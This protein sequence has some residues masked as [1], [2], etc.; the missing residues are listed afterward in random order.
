MPIVKMPDGSRVKFPDDMTPEQI[1][2]VIESQPP[3]AP[4][5]P[6]PEAAPAAP[7]AVPMSDFGP[8]IPREAPPAPAVEEPLPAPLG[9]FGFDPLSAFPTQHRMRDSQSQAGLQGTARG[10]LDTIG[11]PA[12][13]L[14]TA[15]TLPVQGAN[16]LLDTNLP[17]PGSPTERAADSLGAL[18]SKYTG[19]DVR[20]EEDMP[21][22]DRLAYNA[23]RYGTGGGLVGGLLSKIGQARNA[24][25]GER[26][27]RAP[28]PFDPIMAPYETAPGRAVAQDVAAG[29][30]GGTALGA[31]HNAGVDNPL[32]DT[33]ALFLGAPA[34]ITAMNIVESPAKLAGKIPGFFDG[35]RPG[36]P[37]EGLTYIKVGDKTIAVTNSMADEAARAYQSTLSDPKKFASD[38][39]AGEASFKA[40]GLP[41]PTTA[42]LSNDVGAILSENTMRAKNPEPFVKSDNALRDAAAEAVSSVRKPGD[43]EAATGYAERYVGAKREVAQRAADK[44]EGEATGVSM[45]REDE[46]AK[47]RMNRDQK[48]QADA[49]TQIYDQFAGAMKEQRGLKNELFEAP[50]LQSE[51]VSTSPL[52]QAAERVRASATNAQGA[53]AVPSTLI[54]DILKY[55][56][57]QEIPFSEYQQF[58]NRFATEYKAARE[59]NDGALLKNL[60][61]LRDTFLSGVDEVGKRQ[62]PGGEAA[63]KA[64]DNYRQYAEKYVEGT[65]G[66]MKAKVTQRT[67]TPSEE[68]Y[69]FLSSREA[70]EQLEKIKADV[71]D[72]QAVTAAQRKL[73]LGQAAAAVQGNKINP[74]AIRAWRDDNSAVLSTI[75]GLKQEADELVRA[76]VN[77]KD[78]ENALANEIRNTRK[79][80]KATE[81]DLKKSRLSLLL[82]S[83]PENAVGAVFSDK[84]A[85]EAMRRVVKRLGQNKEAIEG[86]RA[87]V[88]DYLAKQVQTTRSASPGGPAAVSYARVKKLFDDNADTLSAVYGPEEM[89]ALRRAQ[90]ILEP[91]T[92]QEFRGTV[93]SQ[94]AERAAQIEKNWGLLEAGLKAYYGVLKGGGVL[95]TTRLW[96]KMLPDENEAIQVLIGKAAFDPKVAAHLA[97]R[98]VKQVGTPAWNRRLTTLLA[99]AELQRE[100]NEAAE[101]D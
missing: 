84:N 1:Q 11:M 44:A 96:A 45:A 41:V 5:Q 86:W 52:R 31:L 14:A 38:V 36:A 97:T 42:A 76:A 60:D 90:K 71:K 77:G 82:D 46:A 72:P 9:S 35:S 51:M 20:D 17:T 10:V 98:D 56:E 29:V 54:D 64:A 4:A 75:P 101:K 47:L 78:K 100:N 59:A 89:N 94:T 24:K 55:G 62:T 67:G 40:D 39:L 53:G 58:R 69:A 49:S 92:K 8:S 2:G 87:A 73:L 15:Y 68:G 99:G 43:P 50:E 57:G 83:T 95:R 66:D 32:A 61:T 19:F 6:V 65:G 79:G 74:Q 16:A 88:S 7:P 91:L 21:P 27:A 70:A 48:T 85:P 63:R 23:A 30:G 26:L 3:A 33:A 12:D 18:A 37:A 22:E 81:D 80:I 25:F 93:G 28:K 34:G 13:L